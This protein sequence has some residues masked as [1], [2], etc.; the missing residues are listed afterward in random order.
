M[1][2]WVIK[3]FENMCFEMKVS[4]CLLFYDRSSRAEPERAI[5]KEKFRPFK[6]KKQSYYVF[7]N[8]HAHRQY[9]PQA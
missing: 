2:I 9:L 5:Q 6:A 4:V 3:D 1:K 7:W 8:S